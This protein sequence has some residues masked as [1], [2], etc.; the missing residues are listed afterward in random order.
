MGMQIRA[1]L[2]QYHKEVEEISAVL[3]GLKGR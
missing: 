1:L 2:M 3:N